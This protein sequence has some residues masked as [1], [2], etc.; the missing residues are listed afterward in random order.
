MEILTPDICIIG[1][2]SGGLSLAA[3]AA[4]MGARVVLIEGGEMGGD[5]LNSGCV[6]SKALLAAGKAAQAAR[7]AGRFGVRTGP[8]T[9]DFAAAKDHVLA[10]IAA[11]AP[12]DSQARFEGLGVTV[13][14]AYA[15][16][17]GPRQVEAAGQTI[18][19]RRFVIATGSRPALPAIP[20]LEAVPH[21]TNETI[22]ALRE[23]PAHLIILGGGPIGL[24]MA[25]AHR[26][27]GCEVTVVEAA[28]ALGR[29][30]PEAAA[31][32]VQAL[33]A[34]GVA[35][36]EGAPAVRIRGVGGGLEVVL[37][38]GEV[39]SG[40]HL[41]VAAGRIP[42]LEPLDLGKAGV[43]VTGRGVKVGRDLRSTTNRRV[44]AI[45][46]VAGGAQ[47]T[48]AA[49]AHAGVV[50]RQVLLGLPAR[51]AVEV[52]W[53]TYTEPELAQTGLT[54]AQ[55][56]QTFGAR[57]RVL[58]ADLAGNDRALAEGKASGFVK[59]MAVAGRPVGATIVGPN[60]GEL[61]AFWAL[62]ISQ[63]TKLSAIAGLILPY[64]TL[65]ESAK[66]VAGAYFSDKLFDNPRL[67]QLVRLVQR[68]V[69]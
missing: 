37:G 55:A 16:F 64:P 38:N 43:A 68:L 9:V 23:A 6:P 36:H 67:R 44:Y 57:V 25:L 34:E 5:C 24:E 66:R 51:A 65:S 61:I 31:V 50:I 15:R 27:L 2:G 11:I 42:V 7:T 28:K 41:L 29:D 63:R 40:S 17:T 47:F 53:V 8:V 52:P 20:G 4:Q 19:A 56:R 45:G 32:V 10:T 1:A 60:A 48:H 54:E 26:R 69:R 13:I 14:R 46:D 33:R 62:A 18:C 49:G 30:D 22:F 12:H 39:V 58:R 21:F 3:G 35:L 59:V